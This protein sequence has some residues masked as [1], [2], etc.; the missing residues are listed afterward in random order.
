[1]K[2][3]S[4]RELEKAMKDIEWVVDMLLH[5][6]PHVPSATVLA[7]R[8]YEALTRIRL[9]LRREHYK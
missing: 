4:Q 2:P 7:D 3:Y 1:M 6:H 5:T 9:A 8:L